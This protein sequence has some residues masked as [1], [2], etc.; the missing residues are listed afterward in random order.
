[1]VRYTPQ[2]TI[3]Q[4]TIVPTPS[5]PNGSS[6]WYVTSPAV[7]LSASGYWAITTHFALDGAPETTYTAQFAVSE[8]VHTL[9]A[10]SVDSRGMVGPTA[11]KTFQVDTVAPST[12]VLSLLAVSTSSASVSWTASTDSG[13]GV[14]SY[15]LHAAD[16]SVVAVTSETQVALDELAPDTSYDY[17]VVVTDVAGNASAASNTLTVRTT[18]PDVVAPETEI[19]GGPFGTW[20]NATPV[21][22]ALSVTDEGDS[23][24]AATYYALNGADAAVYG[25]DSVAVSAEGT[26]TISFWS[27]DNAGNVEEPKSATVMI[28][29]IAPS[30]PV[31]TLTSVATSTAT[32]SWTAS[33]DSGSGVASY[34]LHAADGSVVAVT[35]ETGIM[36]DE[37]AP[38]ASYAYYV[39]ANDVAGNTSAASNT[40]SVETEALDTVAPV[41]T[42]SGGPFSSWTRTS[43]VAFDLSAVDEGGSGVAATSYALNGADSVAYAARERHLPRARPP[44]RSGR[45]TTRATLRSQRARRS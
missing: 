24:V 20:T 11:S 42:I 10:Y 2:A 8:G 19:S 6:G 25:G 3:P 14:A 22:F 17:Y 4:T 18:A 12:P 23:G 40:V 9:T 37:L 31:L 16:G 35:S 5:D 30:I 32:L 36:L 38:D 27:T 33:T 15:T 39:T 45:P 1:M 43:P 7:S 13:S 21:S 26:T 34:T 44:S 41:T 29:T 28:D